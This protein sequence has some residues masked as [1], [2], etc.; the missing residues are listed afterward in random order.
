M[1]GLRGERAG[2]QM[3]EKMKAQEKSVLQEFNSLKAQLF[4]VTPLPS[5]PLRAILSSASLLHP[6]CS[7]SAAAAAASLLGAAA[8]ERRGLGEGAGGSGEEPA[9]PGR[10]DQHQHAGPHHDHSYQPRP[11]HPWHPAGTLPAL[12]CELY[13]E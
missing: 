4:E 2:R 7:P 3:E 5:P 9:G 12:Q 6:C 8:S 1:S 10:G 11:T 13:H